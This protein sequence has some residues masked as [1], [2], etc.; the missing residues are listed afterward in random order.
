MWGMPPYWVVWLQLTGL[1]AA[2]RL[3]TVMY[4]LILSFVEARALPGEACW[5]DIMAEQLVSLT[6][7]RLA[8]SL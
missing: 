4:R 8:V 1:I 3:S 6:A 2:R 5:L 7:M